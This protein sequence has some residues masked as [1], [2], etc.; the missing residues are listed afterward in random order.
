MNLINS[1][2]T[3]KYAYPLFGRGEKNRLPIS[4]SKVSPYYWWWEFL[5]RNDDYRRCCQS[6]GKGRLANLYADFGDVY[7]LEFRLWWGRLKRGA[8]LFGENEIID[9]IRTFSSVEKCAEHLQNPS[10]L[11]AAIPINTPKSK[12]IKSFKILLNHHHKTQRG[13]PKVVS[14]S[15]Y[16]FYAIPNSLALEQ[17]L[18]VY[19]AWQASL[20]AGEKKTLADIGIELRLVREFM[21]NSKDT[22]KEATAKRNKMSATVSR[23]IGDAQAIITNTASGRFP[24]K[25]R[26]KSIKKVTHINNPKMDIYRYWK[27]QVKSNPKVALADI[28]FDLKL[29]NPSWL[30]SP[31]DSEEIIKTKRNKMSATVSRYLKNAQSLVDNLEHTKKGFVSK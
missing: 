27:R 19:D 17:T 16:P 25:S 5:R 6:G 7:E 13:R 2:R 20:K 18:T 14:N 23:Y 11:L 15:K 4:H 10:I 3:F 21:P 30:P 22:P 1:V 26:P 8:Y 29:G 9:R 24:D 28:G 31:T 12:L